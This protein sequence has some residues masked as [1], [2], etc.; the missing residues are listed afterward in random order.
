MNALIMISLCLIFLIA[1]IFN[2]F[3]VF[4]IRHREKYLIH[5]SFP[6]VTGVL[7][8]IMSVG[9]GKIRGFNLNDFELLL[10]SYGVVSTAIYAT[11]T[12]VMVIVKAII[13]KE[14]KYMEAIILYGITSIFCFPASVIFTLLGYMIRTLLKNEKKSQVRIVNYY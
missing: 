3:R 10:I 8:F 12:S 11:I 5:M 7:F 13:D 2:I 4:K 9:I 6:T 14:Y 1:N